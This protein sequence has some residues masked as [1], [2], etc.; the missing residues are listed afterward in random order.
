MYF[1]KVKITK[2]VEFFKHQNFIDSLDS[3]FIVVMLLKDLT[4]IETLK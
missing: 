2:L 4:L 3:Y 1:L